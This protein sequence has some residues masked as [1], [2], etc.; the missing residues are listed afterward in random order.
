MPETFIS[1]ERVYDGLL[2]TVNRDRVGLP[3]GSESVRE[4]IEHPGA[5]AVVPLFDDGSTVLVRQFRYATGRSFLEV[6]AG[7]I[8]A[9]ETPAEVAI[10][11]LEEETGWRAADVEPLGAMY[12]CIGYSDEVIHLFIARG[13]E[14]GDATHHAGEEIEVVRMPFAEAVRLARAGEIEDGKSAVALLRAADRKSG[15]KSLP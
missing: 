15:M 12:P 6:P 11:E 1:R 14:R 7:K 3:D 10:R 5:A 13:L 2:L 4:W 8:D 9:G